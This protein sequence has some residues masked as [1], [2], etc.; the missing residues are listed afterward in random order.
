MIFFF[1]ENFPKKAGDVLTRFGHSYID[2]RG[3]EDEGL[4][5]NDIFQLCKINNAIFLTT[6]KDFYHTVHI[7]QKPHYGI[8][9]IALKQPNGDKII[10]KLTWF[11]NTFDID[12][13]D[14]KCYLILDNR[15]R[16][17]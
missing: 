4:I 16:I 13:V 8:V 2:I 6:D 9:V 1:D 14:N 17:Y 7:L 3:T 10:E 12:N 15:C 5:D 11:L